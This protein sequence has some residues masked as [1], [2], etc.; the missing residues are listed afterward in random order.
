[1][2]ALTSATPTVDRRSP[3]HPPIRPFTSCPPD[4]AEISVS[5]RTASQK[6]SEGPKA[7]ATSAN[8]GESVSRAAAPIRPPVTLARQASVMARSPSPR[9]AIGKPSKVVAMA[10][11]VPG[12]FRR[13]AE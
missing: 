2:S 8:S 13:I 12:V 6:Y 1:M 11:G 5:P 3:K 9:L 10:E 4:K 7:R